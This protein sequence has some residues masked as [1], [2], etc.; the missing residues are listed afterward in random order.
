[1]WKNFYRYGLQAFSMKNI[2]KGRINNCF[3]INDKQRITI[4]KRGEYVKFKNFEINMKLLFMNYENFESI[5]IPEDNGKQNREES[6]T[7]KYQEHVACSYVYKLAC[8]DDKFSKV[9][10][11][12]VKMPFTVLLIVCLKKA[13][14]VLK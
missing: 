4:P 10:H 2:L 3:K 8:L 11:I 9:I 13:S 14:T 6:Y 12:Q 1:M 7:S 5:L